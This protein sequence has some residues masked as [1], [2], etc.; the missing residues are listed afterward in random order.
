VAACV[1]LCVIA[2]SGCGTPPSAKAPDPSHVL[3]LGVGYPPG[4]TV[5]RLAATF[6]ADSLVGNTWNGRPM[7]RVVS[8]WEWSPD[9]RE[10]KLH[11]RPSLK[12]HDGS[13]VTIEQFKKT[14]EAA[15]KT[16]NGYQI[17]YASI[18][19][20]DLD[21]EAKDAVV[22][23]LSRPEAFILSDLA[24]STL[25]HPDNRSIGTGPFKYGGAS[26]NT[27]RLTS[28][29]DYYRGQPTL[30]EVELKAFGEPRGS[31]AAL[32]R[33]EV[34]GVHEIAPNVANLPDPDGQK[35]YPFIRPYFIQLAFNT[36][37]PAL[38]NPVVRQALS[39][40][41]DRAAII[42]LGMN[43]QGVV[44]EGPIWPYHWAYSTAQKTYAHNLEAATLRLESA[45]LKMG[46]SKIG[47]MPSRLH[48]RCLAPAKNALFEKVALV[49]QKQLYEIGVD[50]E[51]VPMIGDDVGKRLDAGDFETVL[52]QRASGRALSWAY[53]TFHSSVSR[54]GYSAA[55]AVLD[56]L[57]NTD[58]ESEIRA[59][60]S[61][62]QQIFHDDPPAIFIAWP[63]TSRVV[64]TRITIPPEDVGREVAKE[65][66]R[67]V[68][69]SLWMWRPADTSR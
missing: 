14:L 12:W 49:L 21:P 39:Y 40:G 56:R 10:L 68:L 45:G 53:S 18:T 4:A 6:V 51:I 35:S 17:S 36:R 65:V 38:K 44:A 19:S 26:G 27:I 66:G 32:M 50:L 13:P 64:S 1:L 16:P 67:D 42:E 29:Q 59:A 15:V 41:V 23:T 60:V 25:E 30:A 34:E 58:N 7:D 31:W 11:L 46:P 54:S 43:K 63:K 9:R 22:V 3:R 5:E 37:H 47:R 62:L 33:G 28:F 24:A 20:I 2:C 61:D 69:S 52:I 57:R 48:I 8:K 55:D